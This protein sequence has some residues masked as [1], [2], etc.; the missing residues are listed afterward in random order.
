MENA[1]ALKSCYNCVFVKNIKIA[2]IGGGL[3]GCCAAAGLSEI[4]QNITLFES[5]PKLLGEA[6]S[7]NEGRIHLGYTY[8]MDKTLNT[9]RLMAKTA[10]VFEK[11]LCMW[12]GKEISRVP[13]STCFNYTVHK[14]GLL[15][16]DE[17]ESHAK[18]VSE[19]IR[20]VLK[21]GDSCFGVDLKK[22]PVKLNSSFLSSNYNIKNITAVF[23][24]NEISVDPEEIADIIRK[25]IVKIPGVKVQTDTKVLKLKRQNNGYELLLSDKDNNQFKEYFDYVINSSGRSLLYFDSMAGIKPPE[26]PLFRL[27]YLIRTRNKPIEIPSTTI[28]LGKFGDTVNFKNFLF[29]SWYPAGRTEWYE[30]LTPQRADPV[31]SREP[32]ASDL[33]KEIIEGLCAVIPN[34]K[35]MLLDELDLKGNWIYAPATTDVNNPNSLLHQRTQVGIIRKGNYFS[36][37]PGKY[38]TAPFFAEELAGIFKN[39]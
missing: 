38:T 30:G 26:N 9:S 3:T 31:L 4:S 36:L 12:F 25:N 17:F 5:G 1:R 29:L 39:L 7:F 20:Q 18:K 11:L 19:I 13:R 24:T 14:Q 23:E 33:K 16:S 15:T 6:S 35:N 22:P 21:K 27:K 8:G 10:V 2:V 37:N 34:L 32:E 28:V